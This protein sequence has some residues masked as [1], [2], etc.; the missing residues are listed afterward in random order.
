MSEWNMGP[1]AL[2]DWV[3]GMVSNVSG[4]IRGMVGLPRAED[5]KHMDDFAIRSLKRHLEARQADIIDVLGVIDKE[6]AR[7][8]NEPATPP[9]APSPPGFEN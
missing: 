8:T 4:N 9:V 6:L 1:G 2:A 5:L 3:Q 7:R